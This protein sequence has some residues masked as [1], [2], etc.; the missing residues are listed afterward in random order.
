MAEFK[1]KKWVKYCLF[2][3]GKLQSHSVKGERKKLGPLMQSI[4]QVHWKEDYLRSKHWPQ[5]LTIQ[6]T[7]YPWNTTKQGLCNVSFLAL[8][9]LF[10]SLPMLV[11]SLLPEYNI[12]R[13]MVLFFSVV[14]GGKERK[15]ENTAEKRDPLLPWES[16]RDNRSSWKEYKKYSFW[17]RWRERASTGQS[18]QECTKGKILFQSLED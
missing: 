6:N 3:W 17:F 18:N 5:S 8:V 15:K 7:L 10:F 2:I 11:A 14:K 16:L 12:N 13:R 9:N 1:C 4:C